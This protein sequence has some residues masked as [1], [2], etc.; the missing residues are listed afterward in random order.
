M[1]YLSFIPGDLISVYYLHF[2]WI[3]QLPKKCHLLPFPSLSNLL[4]TIFCFYM[5]EI[6]PYWTLHSSNYRF[7]NKYFTHL[8]NWTHEVW[9]DVM[10]AAGSYLTII[11]SLKTR[12]FFLNVLSNASLIDFSLCASLK[13]KGIGEDY[14]SIEKIHL[15]YITLYPDVLSVCVITWLDCPNQDQ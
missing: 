1:V 2:L 9:A 4:P 10:E 11:N 6:F 12:F 5:A 7:K 13:H 14:F 15:I 3:E 8:T